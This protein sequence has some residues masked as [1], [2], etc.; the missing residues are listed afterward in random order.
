MFSKDS[1][2]KNRMVA[3]RLDS[4]YLATAVGQRARP[5]LKGVHEADACVVGAGYT[6]L[7]TALHLA[8][9]GL[10]VAVLEAEYAG[11]GAS[12]R[13][14]GQV[15]TGQRVDQIE[16]E[17]RCGV[18]HARALWNSA[19]EAKA[20]VRALI[21]AHEIDCDVSPGHLSAAAKPAHAVA[22]EQEAAH[23]ERN[24]GYTAMRFVGMKEMPALVATENYHG[25]VLDSAGFHLHALNYA[26]GLARACDEAGVALFEGSRVRRIKRGD[27]LRLT[28]D[29]GEVVAPHAV[30][31]CDGYLGELEPEL[32]R[33][34]VPIKNYI[35]AT[36]PLGEERARALIPCGAAVADTKFVLDYYRLSADGRLLFGGGETY[37]SQDVTGV[38]RF[39]RR[40]MLRVFPRL[41]DAAIDYAWGGNVAI[42]LPRLPH[43]GR[44]TSNLYFAQGYSGQG[45]ALATL[46]GK[47]I[48]ETVAGQ[49]SKF[50]VYESLK[51]PPM[52]GGTWL[53]EPL[54]ALGMLWYALRDRLG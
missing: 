14:G 2:S 41:A 18:T 25:G 6:G 9:T 13:N 11:F 24:Y 28:T 33:R 37:G 26:L 7:S 43:L 49:T 44:L 39:V 29:D 36:A 30:V 23:L 45:V 51:I 35:I 27:R 10:K 20:L 4:Y 54:A 5:S 3:S 52:P 8:K 42:T 12:G 38:E 22:L 1:F 32:A 53:Q 34:I 21:A 16:L 17:R 15:I 50:D 19:L 31:A 48:A 40:Y 46:A 47:L